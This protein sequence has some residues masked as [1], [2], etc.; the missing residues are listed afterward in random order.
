ME[1]GEDDEENE[2]SE[3]KKKKWGASGKEDNTPSAHA[4][5]PSQIR[6]IFHHFFSRL[7]PSSFMSFKMGERGTR[8]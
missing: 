4:Q 3:E 1:T 8:D 7:F 2:K 6:P 5:H